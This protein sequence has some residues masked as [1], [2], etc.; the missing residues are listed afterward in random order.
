M[1]HIR[2]YATV[3]KKPQH[4]V[5]LYVLYKE[6]ETTDG[7]KGRRNIPGGYHA[8]TSITVNL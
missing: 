5:I 4:I 2:E 6:D 8:L 7:H 1:R 3:E